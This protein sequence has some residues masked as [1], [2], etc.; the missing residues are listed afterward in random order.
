M[1]PARGMKADTDPSRGHPESAIRT[2]GPP[3]R[4][5]PPSARAG[6]KADPS[7]PFAKNATGFGMTTG[8]DTATP[9]R[10]I[11]RLK[12]AYIYFTVKVKLPYARSRGENLRG[13]TLRSVAV[14][15]L[16]FLA[17][18]LFLAR[19]NILLGWVWMGEFI[20]ENFHSQ[21]VSIGR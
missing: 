20:G 4:R 3:L 5:A 9:A 15:F 16:V 2:V 12:H 1:H 13:C 6:A 18:N 19:I 10:C 14:P 17:F 21:F 7:P 11:G 8:S